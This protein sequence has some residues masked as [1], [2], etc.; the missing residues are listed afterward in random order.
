[1]RTTITR[2]GI[3]AA[4]IV[5]GLT[6]YGIRTASMATPD[7]TVEPCTYYLTHTTAPAYTFTGACVAADGRLITR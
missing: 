4:L 6:G 7:I 3:V 2:A 1:M 5:A